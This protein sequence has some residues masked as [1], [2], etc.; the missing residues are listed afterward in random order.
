MTALNRPI[1]AYVA[2]VFG[3]RT[4]G[5]MASQRRVLI[6]VAAVEGGKL[7]KRVAIRPKIEGDSVR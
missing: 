3:Y 4:A 2:S 5:G 7:D 1:F 6:P